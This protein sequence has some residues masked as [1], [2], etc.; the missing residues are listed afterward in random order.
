MVAT[1]VHAPEQHRRA[2]DE[3]TPAVV[4]APDDAD[5]GE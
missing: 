2:P 4:A 5:A 1:L 3:H